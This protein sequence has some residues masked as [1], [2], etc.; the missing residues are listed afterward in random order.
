MRDE[1][2]LVSTDVLSGTSSLVG[3]PDEVFGTHKCPPWPTGFS[4]LAPCPPH[5]LHSERRTHSH[6][7]SVYA[8]LSDRSYLWPPAAHHPS[9]QG[10]YAH[11]RYRLEGRDMEI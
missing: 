10:R 7:L 5:G 6:W 11:R 4:Y 3:A 9:V 2:R 8:R 1:G